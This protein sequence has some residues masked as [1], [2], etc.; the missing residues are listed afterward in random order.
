MRIAYLPCGFEKRVPLS[1]NEVLLNEIYGSDKENGTVSDRR[2]CCGG[3]R[4]SGSV[5]RVYS[6]LISFDGRIEHSFL[7]LRDGRA[8]YF[9]TQLLNA[10]SFK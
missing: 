3:C 7:G 4:G 2:N 5:A 8:F 1:D 10:V 9:P 6:E